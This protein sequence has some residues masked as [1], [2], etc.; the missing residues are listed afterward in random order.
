[1]NLADV[2]N[3]DNE[4]KRVAIC[5]TVIETEEK[6]YTDKMTGEKRR[7][8][9]ITLQQNNDAVEMVLWDDTLQEYAEKIK[10]LKDNVIVVS[11]QIRY[12]DY[13]G[14][15]SLSSYKSTILEII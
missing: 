12:S 3:L 14:A 7:F 6:S 4:S 15:N 1:M 13:L 5:A 2:L 9:K 10:N 8:L 11:A